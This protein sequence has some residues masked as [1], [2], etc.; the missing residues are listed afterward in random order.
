MTGF[1]FAFV[2]MP[3]PM[4]MCIIGLIFLLLFGNRM[5]GM[6]RGLGSSIVEF[7]KGVKGI[8]DLPG[9]LDRDI[10]DATEKEKA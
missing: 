8:E 4:E 10:R 3:G 2:G 7:K 1:L 5:P 6:M 9:D